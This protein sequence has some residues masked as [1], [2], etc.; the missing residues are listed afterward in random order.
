[1]NDA[2]RIYGFFAGLSPDHAGRTIHDYLE[3]SNETL[4]LLHDYIQ[5]AFPTRQPSQCQAANAPLL[6]DEAVALVNGDMKAQGN[7][8]AMWKR[9]I[10]FYMETKHWLV[11][12]N[13]NHMRITRIIESTAE[14][15]NVETAEMFASIIL[16]RNKD[17][18]CPINEKSVAFWLRALDAAM[19]RNDKPDD[20]VELNDDG[21]YVPKQQEI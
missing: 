1:M 9:I 13:H 10:K 17:A 14:F 2:H 20:D 19:A 15:F 4:E 18:S 5:W 3:M 21:Y 7:Y 6:S 12:V 11:D 16:N 8:Y